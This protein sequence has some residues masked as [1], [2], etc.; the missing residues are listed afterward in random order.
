MKPEQYNERMQQSVYSYLAKEIYARN[1]IKDEGIYD[2]SFRNDMISLSAQIK[3]HIIKTDIEPVY[4]II[5]CNRA[6]K[7]SRS[8]SSE[9]AMALQSELHISYEYMKENFMLTR[10]ERARY[11]AQRLV[12]TAEFID[13]QFEGVQHEY[14]ENKIAEAKRYIKKIEICSKDP[15]NSDLELRLAACIEE[16]RYEEAAH[17]KKQIEARKR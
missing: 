12:E 17:I 10:Y 7:G 6:E 5:R 4:D 9:E 11:C 1:D 2:V 14:L 15:E 13:S 3:G 8:F 16:E